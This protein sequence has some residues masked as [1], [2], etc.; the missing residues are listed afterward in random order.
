MGG[1]WAKW[2][3][4]IKESICDEHWVLYISNESILPFKKK[5]FIYLFERER[6]GGRGGGGREGGRSR[7]SPEQGA[8][9]GT[10]SQDPGIITFSPLSHPGTLNS[11]LKPLLHY[12]LT[13]I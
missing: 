6:V 4:G 11:T 1:E 2:V 8:Q 3:M 13:R 7:L 12:I 9:H 5:D 10:Q